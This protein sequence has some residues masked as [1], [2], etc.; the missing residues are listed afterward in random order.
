MVHYSPYDPHGGVHD[1]PLVTGKHISAAYLL[2]IE[3]LTV[4][5]LISAHKCDF[6]IDYLFFILCNR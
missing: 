4:I 1:G 5:V 6:I 3:L 2:S